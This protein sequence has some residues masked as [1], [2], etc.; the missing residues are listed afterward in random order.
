MLLAAVLAGGCGTDGTSDQAPTSSAPPVTTPDGISLLGLTDGRTLSYLV[1]DTVTQLY[2]NYVVDVATSSLNLSI[3]GTDQDWQI[4]HDSIPVLNMKVTANAVLYNGYWQGI[5]GQDSLFYFS[6]PPITMMKDFDE[7]S[8]WEGYCPSFADSARV[9]YNA[10]FGFYFTKNY[11][12][13]ERLY[14]PAGEFDAYRFDVRL[15]D[16]E[17]K[18]DV[19]ITL[20]EHYAPGVGLVQLTLRGGALVRTLSLIDVTD[21]VH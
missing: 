10:Y 7:T 8:S 2:P 4:K 1:T 21:P 12:G 5:A 17:Q 6:A 16:S 19:V 13:I 9:F 11:F 3:S 18:R 20:T 14:L 15:F